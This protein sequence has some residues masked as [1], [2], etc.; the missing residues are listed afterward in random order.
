MNLKI[1]PTRL[2]GAVTPPT[3]K[4]QAHRLIL[5]AALADGVS[6]LEPISMSQDIQATISCMEALGAA[7]SWEG[8][9]LTVT[10]IF[11]EGKRPT[12]TE[13]PRFDCGESGSTLRFLIPVA[14]AVAGG[15]VFTGHGRLM[16]RPQ[17]PYFRLF[18][19]KGID[20]AQKDGV[21][22]VR[23]TL[24]PGD[25][26][27]PGNVS[28][29]FFT[30]LLFA[31]PL[32]GGTSRLRATTPLESWDYI[33]MTIDT[34]TGAGVVV[35]GNEAGDAFHITGPM[36][37]LPGDRTVE[38]DWSNAAFWYAAAFL[39]SR[40]EIKGL[41][42]Q[43]TQGDARIARLYWVL[44][45]P[46]DAEIDVSQCPDLVPPLAVMAALRGEGKTTR[47]V[48]A[49]RLRLKES[50]RLA[51]VTEVLT[52]LGAQMEEGPD[53]LRFV[54]ANELPGG[55]TVSGH[56]DHR[57]AMMAAVAAIGCLAPVT[58]TG[59]ECVAKSYP[60]FW[61]DYQALGGQIEEV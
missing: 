7:F 41:N 19:E 28:S 15:G 27:L 60:D 9:C 54:G 40:L 12:F 44:A 13:L 36:T 8:Q 47:L 55:T 32:V 49:G 18:E 39:D 38:A 58:V 46:G 2:H 20:Y 11:T 51:T 43:S 37:Y 50:D 59:A 10:G 21:L 25:Y 14:L 16:E 26:E 30:G 31:L 17:E 23:G 35:T 53:F 61:R 3:S 57:I 6:R 42:H 56:N 33:A 5:T 45:R 1:L 4:S 48:N 29:Q 24:Q 34:L 52:A 22:T